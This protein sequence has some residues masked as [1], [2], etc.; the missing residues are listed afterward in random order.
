MSLASSIAESPPPITA[1]GLSRNIGA[2]PSQTAQAEIPRF[3]KP[4]EPSPEP[5]KLSRLATAPVA[6]ITASARTA[7]D[8][9][10][11]LNGF[12]VKSTLVTVSVKIVVPNL[13]DCFRNL[14]VSS[15][16]SIPSKN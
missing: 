4:P 3:Q 9:V 5:G 6:R 14:S 1:R 7:L 11:S 12:D 13:S 15:A 8:S 2:A 10:N 16:P